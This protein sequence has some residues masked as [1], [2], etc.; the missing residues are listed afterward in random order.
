MVCDGPDSM[1]GELV[2]VRVDRATP[3]TLIGALVS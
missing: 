1:I 2:G 3:T